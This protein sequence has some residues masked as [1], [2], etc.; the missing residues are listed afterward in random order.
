MA[1]LTPRG[2][3][4]IAVIAV[5]GPDA[6]RTLRRLFRGPW[7]R[8]VAVG[9]F[10]EQPGDTVVLVRQEGYYEVQCHGGP[11]I[12]EWILEQL[13]RCG[14][15]ET[16]W[17]EWTRRQFPRSIQAAA[18]EALSEA[19][20]LRTAAILLDQVHG[21]LEQAVSRILDDLQ[22]GRCESARFQLEEVLRHAE[23]GLHLTK[24]WRVVFSGRPNVGK[25]S[26][27]NALLGYP[28]AITSPIPGTTRDVV[29]SLTAFDGWPVELVDTAGIREA[30]DMIESEGVAR[31]MQTRTAADLMVEV[32]DRTCP[33]P[34]ETE[35]SRPSAPAVRKLTVIN[36]ADLPAAWH[37]SGL[38]VSA[39][40]GEGLP[41]LMQ[42]IVAELVPYPPKPGEAV[43]FLGRQ[44]ESLQEA[45]RCLNQ[46][47]PDLAQAASSL[48]TVLGKQ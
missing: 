32:L 8:T 40:T 4:A 9:Q 3:G 21:A 15:Q 33:E 47:T 17:R 2:T 34:L 11:A 28:R 25:S 31:A 36:K 37:P 41:E 26:L 27:V 48:Q 5:G 38:S 20:T 1:Q 30:T 12:T 39:L 19:L 13:R 29:S 46:T 35:S 16:D 7:G 18:V 43:P 22:A 14:V 42:A 10:G 23:V 44:Q 45:L 6:E 24:P